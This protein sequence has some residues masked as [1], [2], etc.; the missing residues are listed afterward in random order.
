MTPG[1]GWQRVAGGGKR[2]K[3]KKKRGGDEA[4]ATASAGGLTCRTGAR[5]EKKECQEKR[6]GDR[7]EPLSIL[8]NLGEKRGEKGD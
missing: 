5:K 8:P 2:N 3:K 6:G 1:S 7:S 4:G